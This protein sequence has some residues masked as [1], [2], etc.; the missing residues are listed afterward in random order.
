MLFPQAVTPQVLRLIRSLQSKEYLDGFNL[1]GGTALSLYWGHRKSID[2]DLF[3]DF[4]FDTGSLLEQ[5][6]QD[7]TIELFLTAPNTLKGSIENIK[8]DFIAHRYPLIKE[9]LIEDGVRLLHEHDILAMK[10]NAI[11][12]SGQRSK[13]FIDIW[14]ALKKYRISEIIEFYRIKY[15]QPH[16]SHVLKSLIFFDDA[17]LADWPELLEDPDL[18]WKDI[19]KDIEKSVIQFFRDFKQ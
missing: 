5:I 15:T 16:G 3:S 14:Y 7:F 9:P 2:I 19:R 10:L 13:D 4:S 6:Q 11:S 17:D 8:V 1:V 18:Q 12:M